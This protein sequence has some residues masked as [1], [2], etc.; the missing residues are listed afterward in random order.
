M[1]RATFT[2]SDIT[3]A[4]KGALKAGIEIERIQSVEIDRAG[5]IRVIVG[6]PIAD[7]AQGG[8]EGEWDRI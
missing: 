5:N 3:K 4:L 6:K 8:S 7:P 1:S 2:Q